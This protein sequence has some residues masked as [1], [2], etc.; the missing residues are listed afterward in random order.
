MSGAV[1]ARKMKFFSE[2]NV[3]FL[4]KPY[5]IDQLMERIAAR[6]SVSMKQEK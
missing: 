5:R 2:K 4:R 1:D 6:L 3:E